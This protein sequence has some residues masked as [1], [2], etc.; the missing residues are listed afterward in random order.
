MAESIPQFLARW[1][2][3]GWRGK[4]PLTPIF[5]GGGAFWFF[6]Y[7][8]ERG[9]VNLF[10]LPYSPY[11]M[12]ISPVLAA[13]LHVTEWILLG[14]FIWWCI[15]VW[16]CAEREGARTWPLVARGVVVALVVSNIVSALS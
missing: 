9:I 13:M 6:G 4:A 11:P 16:K 2:A 8:V 14:M 10:L 15:S 1:T 7:G 3:D 5:W 12:E